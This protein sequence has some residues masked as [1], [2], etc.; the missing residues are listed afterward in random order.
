M[1]PVSE[2]NR[3]TVSQIDTDSQIDRHSANQSGDSMSTLMNLQNVLTG[4]M[5]FL[6]A[7]VTY[8]PADCQPD[9]NIPPVDHS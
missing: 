9:N 3:Q 5:C 8:C 6:S 7:T 4:V 2:P 1:E